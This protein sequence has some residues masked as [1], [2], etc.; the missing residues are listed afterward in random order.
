MLP[1]LTQQG[2]R[3]VVRE[4]MAQVLKETHPA[5]ENPDEFRGHVRGL[6]KKRGVGI[7]TDDSLL[8]LDIIPHYSVRDGLFRLRIVGT[9]GSM[10]VNELMPE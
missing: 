3:E 5:S 1:T 8:G 9:V 6:L 2:T 7:F 10:V 4:V